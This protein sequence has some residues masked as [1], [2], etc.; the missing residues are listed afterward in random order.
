VAAVAEMPSCETWDF[1]TFACYAIA[2]YRLRFTATLGHASWSIS[3]HQVATTHLIADVSI[4]LR[5]YSFGALLSQGIHGLASL[6]T[7]KTR[8]MSIFYPGHALSYASPRECDL[9]GIPIGFD[10]SECSWLA[11][12]TSPWRA[13]PESSGA[14][15]WLHREAGSLA[16]VSARPS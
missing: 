16:P 9:Y 10:A 2:R 8:R 12:S 14:T 5:C 11:W 1:V 6:S 3:P 7:C 13:F 4:L 15:A